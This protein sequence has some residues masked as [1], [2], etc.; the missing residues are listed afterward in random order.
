M[1]SGGTLVLESCSYS[2]WDRLGFVFDEY[3]PLHPSTLVSNLGTPWLRMCHRAEL[4]A[5][6]QTSQWLG[7]G[8]SAGYKNPVEYR[9]RNILSEQARC[10]LNTC[11]GAICFEVRTN[12]RYLHMHARVTNRLQLVR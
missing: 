1:H 12:T 2:R 4:V 10:T 7:A 11:D 9:L 6:S 3:R 5:A 8:E